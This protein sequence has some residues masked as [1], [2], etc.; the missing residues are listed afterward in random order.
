MEN[1][2]WQ[3]AFAQNRKTTEL[4][5]NGV[6]SGIKN[7]GKTPDI[8]KKLLAMDEQQLD[9]VMGQRGAIYKTEQAGTVSRNAK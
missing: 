2:Q 1:A 6:E 9:L 7:A 4:D 3:V 8:T 5:M